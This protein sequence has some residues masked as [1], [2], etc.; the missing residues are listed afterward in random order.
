MGV[1]KE[2]VMD[3]G[4]FLRNLR[5]SMNLTQTDLAKILGQGNTRSLIAGLENGKPVHLIT[6]VA[7]RKKFGISID[8]LVDNSG[9]FEELD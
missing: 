3:I 2:I 1:K 4:D 8:E 7:L 9:I 6:L 5:K